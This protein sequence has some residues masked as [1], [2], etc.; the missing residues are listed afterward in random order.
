[1][2]PKIKKFIDD[3][4]LFRENVDKL[5]DSIIRIESET[6]A[7]NEKVEL[8]N[9][10]NHEAIT[11]MKIIIIEMRESIHDLGKTVN[12]ILKEHYRNHPEK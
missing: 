6:K 10:M 7:T 3:F 12:K 9:G 2:L 8:I 5:G 1:M 4:D 11:E